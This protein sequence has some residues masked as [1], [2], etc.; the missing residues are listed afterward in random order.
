MKFWKLASIVTT[1]ALSTN[2]NA[3][4]ISVDWHSA[5][6]NLITRDTVSGLDWLDLTE[7]AGLSYNYVQSQLGAGGAY[8]GMRYAY[9]AEVIGLI[10]QFG[11]PIGSFEVFSPERDLT[12]ITNAVDYIGDTYAPSPGYYGF[13]A[14][15]NGVN[16]IWA[17][18]SEYWSTTRISTEQYVFGMEPDWGYWQTGHFIVNSENQSPIPVPP[19]VWLFSSGLIGLFRFAKSKR[20]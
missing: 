19:A 4:L 16:R 20:A 6:D 17:Y 2:L 7:T 1:L 11:L 8:E 14:V 5:G 18:D 12:N 15:Y 9:Y 13:S 10:T 3:E